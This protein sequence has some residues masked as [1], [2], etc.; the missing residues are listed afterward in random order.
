MSRLPKQTVLLL[1]DLQKA[2]DH[3]PWGSR[4]NPQAEQMRVLNGLLNLRPRGA[5]ALFVALDIFCM[6]A[7]M[8]V[9]VL[10]ILLGFAVG[11]YLVRWISRSTQGAVEILKHLLRYATITSCVTLAGVILIWG[12]TV[13]LL[14]DGKTDLANFG[15]PQIL[16]KPQASFIGWLTL[17]IVISPFLQLLTTIFGG[18]VALLVAGEVE[19]GVDD[20]V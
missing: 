13:R 5:F 3:P 8:G 15:I 4:N 17:M 20:E 18:Y 16:Y 14:F 7:G 9:P 6:G 10:N 19:G 11:W 1:I 12:P 2:I